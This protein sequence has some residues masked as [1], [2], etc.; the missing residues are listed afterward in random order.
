MQDCYRV[1]VPTERRVKRW[2]LS[3]QELVRDP[4]GRQ[5]L[6]TFLESE[7]SSENIRFWMAIQDLKF[8]TNEQ[9]ERKA[10]RIYEEFLSSGA[11]C[12]VYFSRFVTLQLI[13]VKVLFHVFQVDSQIPFCILP[14][15]TSRVCLSFN[16]GY[17]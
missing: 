1:E 17:E 4:I 6:E 16:L 11:P 14:Q 13:A 9:V 2:G 7:F 5:V 10:Q 8:S 3:I 15:S 12:Q